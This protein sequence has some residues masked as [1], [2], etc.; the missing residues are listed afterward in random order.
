MNIFSLIKI[1]LLA[2]LFCSQLSYGQIKSGY[3][4]VGAGLGNISSSSPE[5][6]VYSYNI[7]Y[8]FIPNFTK[9]FD[10]TF[11]FTFAKDINSI[12]PEGTYKPYYSSVQGFSIQAKTKHR[13]KQNI[14]L[15]NG[16]G[17]IY[18]NDR[19]FIDR[20]SWSYGTVFSVSLGLDFFDRL[21]AE[22]G[23]TALLKAEYAITFSKTQ[24]TYFLINLEGR[25]SFN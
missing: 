18:L 2:I 22:E 13:V 20:N 25:Y 4:G 5:R 17:I 16:L 7:F 9:P 12:L 24:P 23:L 1:Y 3:V 6:F 19:V 8:N 11:A 14:F 21:I 10:F 15:E